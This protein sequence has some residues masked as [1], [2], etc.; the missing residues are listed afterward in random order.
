VLSF[1]AR[2]QPLPIR[3]AREVF[4]QAAHPASFVER[5]MRP[6]VRRPLSLRLRQ[7][8]AM[9]G[10]SS[11]NTAPEPRKDIRYSIAA[12][13]HS[14]FAAASAAST[15]CEPSSRR[16]REPRYYYWVIK[17]H[18][19]VELFCGITPLRARPTRETL[20][21]IYRGPGDSRGAR[22]PAG[23]FEELLQGIAVTR[24]TKEH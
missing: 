2:F 16:S 9:A 4:P 12:I 5:V 11:P 23:T 1:L 17:E 19:D 15:E 18:S 20:R 3:T 13:P 21:G 14:T 7:G 24:G 8:R 22:R 6:V 10:F